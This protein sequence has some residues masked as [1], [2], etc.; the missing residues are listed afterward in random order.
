MLD[1]RGGRYGKPGGIEGYPLERIYEEV[2][3]LAYHLHWDADRL[4]ELEHQERRRW[5]DEVAS[6]NRRL[7]EAPAG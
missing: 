4:L 5:I 1:G 2:A 3:Y 6:I 7:N